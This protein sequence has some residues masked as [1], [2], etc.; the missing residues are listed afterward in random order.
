VDANGNILTVRC[1]AVRCGAVRCGAV[2][3]G[4]VRCGAVRC[5]AVRC[6]AVRCSVVRAVHNPKSKGGTVLELITFLGGM[7][8]Q[9]TSGIWIETQ[10]FITPYWFILGCLLF[11]VLYTLFFVPESRPPSTVQ[12]KTKFASCRSLKRIYTVYA[13]A[14]DGNK[15]NLILLTLSSGIMQVALQGVTGV[16]TLYVLH[17]PLCFSPE[18]VG[19]FT[20]WRS[21]SI[22][23]GAIIGIRLLGRWFSELTISRLGILTR[24]ASLVLLAFSTTKVLVFMAPLAGLLNGCVVPIFRAMMSRIVSSDEQGAL[25]SAVASIEAL[26]NFIGAFI[27]NTLYPFALNKLNFQGFPFLVGAFVALVPLCFM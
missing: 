17:S 6:G 26:S 7:V 4:A 23:L 19:Y 16:I 20:A 2:R 5:G 3:C 15:R 8:S 9:V 14:K 11:S 13:S 1:G 24:V 25:F 22:G 21:L 12:E 27:F 18:F 10:G